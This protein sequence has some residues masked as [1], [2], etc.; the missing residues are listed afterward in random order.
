MRPRK[1]EQKRPLERRVL[2]AGSG[3]RG[4]K[5][6]ALGSRRAGRFSREGGRLCLG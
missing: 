3:G 6:S 5:G 2:G 4:G 1:S